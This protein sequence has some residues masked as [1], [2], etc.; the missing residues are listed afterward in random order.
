LELI[1]DISAKLFACVNSQPEQ[2]EKKDRAKRFVRSFN[3]GWQIFIM[4][5][6]AD[7]V[8]T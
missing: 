6:K 5:L 7:N 4:L 2:N 1:S 3:Q 8:S